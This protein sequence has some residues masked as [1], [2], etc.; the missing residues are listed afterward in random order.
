[1]PDSRQYPAGGT[2]APPAA[3]ADPL[4]VVAADR[5]PLVLLGIR[6]ALRTASG[7]RLVGEARNAEDA[8]ALC[9]ATRPDV[10]LLDVDLCLRDDLR[11]LAELRRDDPTASVVLLGT[12]HVR[13]ELARAV[14]AGA[15]GYVVK[16]VAPGDLAAA[17][18]RAL[19]GG[20]LSAATLL[21]G[22]V[23]GDAS[24]MRAI[25][26]REQEI[27]R[28][29]AAG[30]SN[31]QIASA[32]WVSEPTVKFHLSNVYRKLGVSRRA[33]AVRVA[34]SYGIDGAHSTGGPA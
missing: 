2:E 14:R 12:L 9:R 6:V 10:V 20:A 29:V 23:F 33:D 19:D 32:L 28:H 8:L 24:R 11:L 27:L 3:D 34:R 26:G 16:D 7:M 22:A 30:R 4:R 15:A 5:H 21:P 31:A 25:T 13:R 17:I 1:V 18:R